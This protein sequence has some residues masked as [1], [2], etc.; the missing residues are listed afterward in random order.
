M[1]IK[2]IINAKTVVDKYSPMD[3]DHN[4]ALNRKF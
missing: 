2:K 4:I 3:P 1:K